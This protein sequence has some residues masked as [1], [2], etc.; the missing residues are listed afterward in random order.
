MAPAVIFDLR[1]YPKGADAVLNHL[2]REPETDRWMHVPKI[3]RPALPGIPRPR[4]NWDGR[5]WNRRP[6]QPHIQGHVLFLTDARAVSQAE[7]IL[8]YVEMLGID[9]VGSS[10]AGTNGSIRAV[11]LPSGS[12]VTFTGM[13]VTRHDGSRFH[14]EGIRPTIPIEPTVAGIRAGRDEVLDRALGSIRSKFQE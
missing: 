14:L 8:G 5:G 10:T 2:L 4:H 9:I 11:T 7:S 3:F 13:K 12:T 1:G 6:A